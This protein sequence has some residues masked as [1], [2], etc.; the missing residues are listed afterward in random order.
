MS[1][2]VIAAWNNLLGSKNQARKAYQI[3]PGV[4]S[5]HGNLTD[6]GLSGEQACK[7]ILGALKPC[8]N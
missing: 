2:A 5:G 8:S 4:P 6:L 7:M 3:T 1:Q